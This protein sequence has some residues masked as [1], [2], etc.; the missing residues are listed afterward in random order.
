[1]KKWIYSLLIIALVV[2]GANWIITH[3]NSHPR[4]A[5][6]DVIDQFND[7]S[8]YYNGGVANVS[9][10]N[11]TLDGYNLGL[12]YQCVEFIKRYYYQRFG[13]K[14]PNDRGHAK[15]FFL[16]SLPS[17]FL[18]PQRDLIQFHNKNKSSPQVEDIVVFAPWL[19]NRYGHVAIVSKVESDYIE[20]IQQN[21]GPFGSTREKIPLNIN[22]DE[23]TVDHDRLLGWLR[24]Q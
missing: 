24:M 2:S 1:M 11:L 23:Y 18:N 3:L 15:D 7:V 12:E 6:G 10:R 19:F 5:V 16:T 4:Y 8:V 13:H 22:N 21:P 17:D 14:M 20:I 9:G